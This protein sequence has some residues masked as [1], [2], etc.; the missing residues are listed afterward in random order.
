VEK[1]ERAR[2]ATDDN[3]I[4]RICFVCR[5]TSATDTHSEYAIGIAFPR[6]LLL[7]ERASL[8]R[9]NCL[10]IFLCATLFSFTFYVCSF[11]NVTDTINLY[12]F[13]VFL[14]LLCTPLGATG[15]PGPEFGGQDEAAS[16][17]QHQHGCL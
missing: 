17:G 15:G 8:L 1:F 9:V 7:P 14:G 10:Y 16:G 3:T 4:R 6:Q 5:L 11:Q 12:Q 13:V 2:Q